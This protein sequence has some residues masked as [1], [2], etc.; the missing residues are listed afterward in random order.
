MSGI[1]GIS[2]YGSLAQML[3]STSSLQSEYT[4]LDEQ[5]IT[6]LVSQSYS[7]VASVSSQVLDLEATLNQGNAFTQNINQ[8]QGQASAMQNALSELGTLV[9]TLAAT[10]MS[11]TSSTP[12]EMVASLAQ[13]ASDDLSQVAGL[14]NTSFGGNYVFSGADSGNAPITSPNGLTS[15]SMFSNIGSL[16]ASFASGSGTISASALI[17]SASS[18]MATGTIFSAYLTAAATNPVASPQIEIGPSEYVN[19]GLPATQNVG[20][21][22]DPSGTGSAITDILGSL[23]VIANSTTAMA[24]SSNFV[25]LIQDVSTTL[26]SAANTLA[27]ESG[28]IGQAQDTMTAATNLQ[29]AAQTALSGQLTNLTNVDM[30]TAIS[31]LQ[32]VSTQLETSYS[33]LGEVNQLNLASYL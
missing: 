31:N 28:Y 2:S 15:S 5:T 25:S 8:G 14:V 6:G 30:P 4:K 12:P 11:I 20:A 24:S 32:A 9:S 13:Q 23:A 1:T 22:A 33:V 19:L 16:L 3:A 21:S 17:D 27:Q 7:G 29:T 18:I 10:A 26:T